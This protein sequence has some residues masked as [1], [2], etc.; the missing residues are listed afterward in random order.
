M[1]RIIFLFVKNLQIN[2]SCLTDIV[3]I[4]IQSEE[5]EEFYSLTNP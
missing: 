5:T 1:N 4:Q 3:K 2:Q